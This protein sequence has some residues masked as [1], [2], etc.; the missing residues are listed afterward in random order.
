MVAN[1]RGVTLVVGLHVKLESALRLELFLA[2]QDL[3]RDAT[4]A[5]VKFLMAPKVV[6]RGESPLAAEDFA[7]EVFSLQMGLF[8]AL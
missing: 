8:V 4:R 1:V 2:V 5:T 7:G 3:A 6:D